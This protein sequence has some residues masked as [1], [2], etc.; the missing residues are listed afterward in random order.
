MKTRSEYARMGFDFTNYQ[1]AQFVEMFEFDLINFYAEYGSD[2][3]DVQ[4]EELF[5]S[6][7]CDMSEELFS[8]IDVYN[9]QNWLDNMAEESYNARYDLRYA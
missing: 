3:L 1:T 7:D 4:I 8:S 9:I 6:D 2:D 5:F